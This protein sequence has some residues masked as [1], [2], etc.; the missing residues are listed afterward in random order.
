MEIWKCVHHI[1]N[2]CIWMFFF[3]D[4]VAH[5]FWIVVLFVKLQTILTRLTIRD[6]SCWSCNDSLFAGGRGN[7]RKKVLRFMLSFDLKG[8]IYVYINLLIFTHFSCFVDRTLPSWPFWFSFSY[9]HC[10]LLSFWSS[11]FSSSLISP[12]SPPP[13]TPSPT[14]TLLPPAP[15]PLRPP[16]HFLHPFPPQLLP[17]TFFSLASLTF[18]PPPSLSSISLTFL[19][20]LQ[21]PP[22]SPTL[23]LPH[24]PLSPPITLRRPY[25][26]WHG[27]LQ[28][29]H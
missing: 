24:P 6:V 15:S 11:N 9:C 5:F 1:T 29:H 19:H 25:Q 16:L 14:H 18:L 20:L 22:P 17:F 3:L 21:V 12:P 10:C 8:Y 23:L 27:R 26:L 28:V 2:R 7:R 4:I 13:P